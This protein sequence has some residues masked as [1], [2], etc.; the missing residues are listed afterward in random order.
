MYLER[1]RPAQCEL[2]RAH[3]SALPRAGAAVILHLVAPLAK[4]V[5]RKKCRE[6]ANNPTKHESTSLIA[7]LVRPTDVGRHQPLAVEFFDHK[8][9][10][11]RCH[12]SD[13]IVL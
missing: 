1:L 4:P 11:D 8:D 12:D 9:L 6:D 3:A 13:V 2:S 7:T 10:V 5:S